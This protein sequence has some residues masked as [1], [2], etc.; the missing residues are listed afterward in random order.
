MKKILALSFFIFA[1][2]VLTFSW[3]FYAHKMIN[4]LA[5]FTLPA[6]M[7]GFYK[8]H[9]EFISE[10]AVNADK[11]RHMLPHEAECHYIDIDEYGDSALFKIPKRWKDAVAKYTEDSLRAY[12][13]VPWHINFVK[14]QLTE[15]FKQKDARKILKLSSD[16]G[17]YIADAHVPLHTT[18]NYNGQYS[19][20]HGIH[21]FW[22]SRLPE[23]HA[24]Q[25]DF[26]TGKAEYVDDPQER[27]WQAVRESNA[28]LDSVLL[29][30]KQLS[31]KFSEDKKY[32]YEERGGVMVKNYS[33]NFSNAYHR[34]LNGQ[35][36]RRMRSS[37]KMIGDFWYTCWI[38]AGQPDLNSLINSSIDKK[39]DEIKETTP[40]VVKVRDVDNH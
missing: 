27:A 22:E 23:L 3:G 10:N 37:V 12:G 18:R 38:D 32:V 8:H 16:L 1:F 15:A 14:Y 29:F 34:M 40:T 13:I 7:M 33:R 21:A 35:V 19:N 24:E 36:E 31:E 25:Y 11:R 6:E 17:H 28:A 20:Q 2:P 5:V 26:F 39:E 9:I 4:R 30:E